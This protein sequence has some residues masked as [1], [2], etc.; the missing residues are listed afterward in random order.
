MKL[1]SQKTDIMQF[2]HL[3]ECFIDLSVG[4][5]DLILT[6]H[7][8]YRRNIE[9]LVVKVP[10]LFHD[11]Y[12]HGEPSD[13]KINQVLK[14]AKNHAFDRIIA[15]GGGSVM[16]IAKLLVIKDLDDCVDAFERNIA[17]VKDKT[18]VCIPTTCGTGSE[19]TNLTIAEM[20]SK[21]TKMGLGDSALLP[22]VAVLIPELLKDLP[23]NAFMHASIDALIHAMESY[24]S[25]KATSFT[26]L[27]S[28]KAIEL[29]L[30]VFT[31]M[32][33][34]GLDARFERLEN[35]LLASTYA[36][37]AFGN[38]GVGAVHALSY[39]LGGKYHVPHG[40]ANFQFFTSVFKA[41]EQKYPSGKIKKLGIHI[42]KVLV[43]HTDD[44]FDDLENLLERLIKK[45]P[46]RNYG[47]T[48]PEISEFSKTVLET[49]QRLLNNNYTA[50][51]FDDIY[52][53]YRSL[54]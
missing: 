33:R 38:A 21:G 28:L 39:P 6:S 31:F 29:I 36:G 22:D 49:Q 47:M 19:V 9:G 54:Y 50:L 52:G 14:D 8:M 46:L 34:E 2:D 48:E 41:Y 37:I 42:H 12:G 16:D 15:I 45:P 20:T 40:E 23:Y 32:A 13:S 25:P 53:I 5:K 24:L 4:E 7:G 17:L 1:L 3:S 10:I 35:M 27:Y 43:T 51:T 26:E 18:L 11:D 30:D 44:I